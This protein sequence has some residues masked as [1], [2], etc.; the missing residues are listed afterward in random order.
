M[1]ITIVGGGFG[2]VKAARELLK[3]KRNTVTLITDKPD[4]QYYPALYN[5]A[6][7]K[8]P[9]QAWIPLSEIFANA[10]RFELVI[11]PI[12]SINKPQQQLTGKSGT[13]Y[14]YETLIFALG[15][16]TTYFGIEGLDTYAFGIKSHEEIMEL[17]A[18]IHDELLQRATEPKHFVIIGAGPTGVELASTF[19]GYIDEQKKKLNVTT[20]YVVDVIEAAPRVLPRMSERVSNRVTHHL[21]KR[22]VNVMVGKAVQKCEA[23]SLLVA[24]EPLATT[25]VIWTSGV[26]NHPFYKQNESAF[27]FSPNGRIVV[28]QYMQSSD[29]IFVI[30]DNA[31]MPFAGLAQIAVEDAK[32]V[33]ATIARIQDKK[34]LKAYKQKMPMTAVPMGEYWAIFSFKK[35]VITGYM[36]S[37]IRRVADLI[38]YRDILPADKAM[39]VWHLQEQPEEV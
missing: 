4:F 32:F 35:I 39:E 33:A 3:D 25:T 10:T 29:N 31:F 18:H 15:N 1:H 7:G 28:N 24:G 16:V 38:G 26:T 19:S 22:G 2:G 30:G 9:K 34:P 8:T 23:D 5:V 11:D 36:A 14:Q 6:T 21:Q 17:K 13:I 12:V 20:P 27:T 37:R